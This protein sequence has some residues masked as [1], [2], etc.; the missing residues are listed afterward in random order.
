MKLPSVPWKK[1]AAI[2]GG[3]RIRSVNNTSM[4]LACMVRQT[5]LLMKSISNNMYKR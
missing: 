3:V 2:G 4:S 1:N 5:M